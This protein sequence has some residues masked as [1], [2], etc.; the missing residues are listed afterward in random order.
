MKIPLRFSPLLFLLL[1]ALGSSAQD[2]LRLKKG[3]VI[4]S[5]KVN[6]SLSYALYIPTKFRQD[7]KWPVIFS[8]DP[9]A[10]GR[11]GISPFLD[12]AEEYGLIIAC[13]NN[14]QNNTTYDENVKSFEGL[15]THL[16]SI[17]PLEEDKVFVAGFSGGARLATTI[18]V[19]SEGLIKGVIAC[20]AGF[21]S[22]PLYYPTKR[23]LTYIGV[24]GERDFN[25]FEM[26]DNRAYLSERYID[27]ELIVFS[28]DHRWPPSPIMRVAVELLLKKRVVDRLDEQEKQALAE[29]FYKNHYQLASVFENEGK[30]NLAEAHYQQILRNYKSHYDLDSV[31]TKARALRKLDAFKQ[32]RRS[33]A[34]IRLKEEDLIYKYADF[35]FEDLEDNNI[36]NIAWWKKEFEKIEDFK[37]SAETSV[38][39]MGHR[40]Y[41]LLFVM[42]IE[43]TKGLDPSLDVDALIF[44][45][46][47]LIALNPKFHN[48]YIEL[49]KHYSKVGNYDFALG[50][51]EELL[52]NG[53]TNEEALNKVEGIALLRIMPEYKA[54][55]EKY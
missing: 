6:D 22:N 39:N 36:Q 2:R 17:L 48:A 10:R 29:K 1:I 43:S 5:V 20:G 24:V 42:A 55:L 41:G 52:K 27:N 4:D 19:L 13:S 18:A 37:A 47:F 32:Y 23:N 7:K 40:L 38:Q 44:A 12:T 16:S 54:L 26:R 3:A 21:A 8:F 9:V 51:L 50:A 25:Y 15:V 45:N 33:E 28:G 35:Y 53:Y 49:M 46:E 14:T 30:V 11:L 31:K 34:N